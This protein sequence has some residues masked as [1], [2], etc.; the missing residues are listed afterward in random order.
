MNNIAVVR[1]DA[2]VVSAQ[3]ATLAQA[4]AEVVRLARDPFYRISLGDTVYIHE[5]EFAIGGI[6]FEYAIG[7]RDGAPVLCLRGER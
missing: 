5:P 4:E 1:Q 7:Q 3:A 6:R 2:T